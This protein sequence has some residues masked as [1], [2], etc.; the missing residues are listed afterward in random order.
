MIYQTVFDFWRP[1]LIRNIEQTTFYL[2]H[3]LTAR[4]RNPQ[5]AVHTISLFNR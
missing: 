4:I 3:L 1:F 2:D 5:S